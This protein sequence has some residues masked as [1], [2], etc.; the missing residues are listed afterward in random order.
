M[1]LHGEFTVELIDNVVH[2]YPKGGFNAQGIQALQQEIVKIA[3][4]S[5][6]WALFEHPIDEAGLTPE[7]VE[8]IIQSY[9]SLERLNCK[10]IAL[11][12]CQTWLGVFQK[13]IVGAVKIPVFL[14][15]D[16]E[17]LSNLLE[18]VLNE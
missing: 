2:V 12:I 11:E 1:Q 6:P 15:A 10:A 16:K 14:D 7:A 9:L 3:P 4:K 13:E 5:T 17:K 18:Q 8:S